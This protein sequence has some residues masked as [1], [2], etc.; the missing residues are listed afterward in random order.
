MPNIRIKKISIKKN[1]DFR[2]S[3]DPYS[4]DTYPTEISTSVVYNDGVD[5]T[6]R[7]KQ[8]VQAINLINT[9]NFLYGHCTVLLMFLSR[10]FF[11]TF[12]RTR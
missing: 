1:Y 9:A 8:H 11:Y 12:P 5:P 6:C 4:H 7:L 3:F 10:S 2:F